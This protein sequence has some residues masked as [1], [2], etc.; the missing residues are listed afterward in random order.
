MSETFDWLKDTEHYRKKY[1]IP[2]TLQPKVCMCDEPGSPMFDSVK[3]FIMMS[4]CSTCRKPYRWYVRK[5]TNC[6]KW[7]IKD[8]RIK[9]VDCARHEKCWDCTTLPYVNMIARCDCPKESTNRPDFE[10][11]GYNPRVP[12]REEM[13]AAFDMPSAFD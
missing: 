8:F 13:D 9:A 11:L 1:L 6:T 12:T 7:F 3:R 5:C 2:A 10:P 4:C